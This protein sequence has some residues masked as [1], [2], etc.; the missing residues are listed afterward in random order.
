MLII[1]KVGRKP[2][3]RVGS[4][5]MLISMVTTRIIIAKFRRDWVEHAD[6][7]WTAVVYIWVNTSLKIRRRSRIVG[8]L[9][10]DKG[11]RYTSVPSELHGDR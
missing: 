8:R 10:T 11:Y 1:D 9:V 5:V 3:L 7:G 4:I 2:M 6:A